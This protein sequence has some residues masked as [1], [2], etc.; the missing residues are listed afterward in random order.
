MHFCYILQSVEGDR[1]Y[2]GYTNN[3]QRRLRQHNREI[4]GGA[5]STKGR[6]WKYLVCITSDEPWFTKNM[7]LSLEWHIRYP[8]NK[9][10][11]PAKYKGAH[12]RIESLP[13]VFEKEAFRHKMFQ[14]YVNAEY[15]DIVERLLT[16]SNNDTSEKIKIYDIY[17]LFH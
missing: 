11:R 10:P 6:S 14:V 7:A 5:K 1:T 9:K 3:L 2:N 13:L 15:K 8:T 17:E 12:G 4:R 16:S